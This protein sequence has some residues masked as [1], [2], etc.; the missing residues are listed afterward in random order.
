[1]NVIIILADDLGWGD[2]SCHNSEIKTPIISEMATEGTEL[3]QFYAQPICTPTRASLLSGK[4]PF[5]YGMNEIVWPWNSHGMPLTEVLLPKLLKDNGYSTHMIGK[6]N[7]GHASRALKPCSRGFDTHFGCYTGCIDN[8]IHTAINVHDMHEN[9]NPVY[10]LGKHTTS[11]Y[12]YKAIDIINSSTNPF[13]IYLAYNAPHVPL[14]TFA[15]FVSA[16]SY[17]KDEVRRNYAAM[18][19]HLDQSIGKIISALKNKNLL[20][21]TLIWFMSDNGGWIGNGGSNGP[22]RGGKITLYD[23][24]IKV[25]SIIKSSAFGK[26]KINKI[27]HAVDVLPTVLELA[28]IKDIEVRD[29]ESVLK[30]N[31]NR[32]IIHLFKK[33]QRGQF[34]GCVRRNQWKLHCYNNKLELYNIDKDISEAENLV[35]KETQIVD[36]LLQ[37]LKGYWGQAVMDFSGWVPPN[38]IPPKFPLPRYWGEETHQFLQLPPQPSNNKD[39]VS[40]DVAELFGYPVNYKPKKVC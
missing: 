30:D 17:I 26:G 15:E 19:C 29:G 39:V 16:N 37:V 32:Q 9:C 14:Q 10:L 25:P 8:W 23:G 36:E 31:N 5:R 21:N 20:D 38:G 33:G 27:S 28:N 34:V 13:F 12:T 4:Y 6:W 7:L 18:V 24:G 3:T 40:M 22:L 1:M 2:L 11:L 35:H